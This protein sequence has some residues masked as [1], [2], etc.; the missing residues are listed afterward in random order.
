MIGLLRL[1]IEAAKPVNELERRVEQQE[2]QITNHVLKIL[3]LKKSTYHSKWASEISAFCSTLIKK[4]SHNKKFPKKEWYYKKLFYPS[5][6]TFEEYKI[7]VL[8]KIE[9]FSD[10]NDTFY[11][12]KKYDVSTKENYERLKIFYKEICNKMSMGQL[13]TAS[14]ILK[15]LN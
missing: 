6:E 1:I 13:P 14:Q 7:E 5:F 8:N 9:A 3:I 11:K 4:Q 2:S 10:P 12:I 15:L